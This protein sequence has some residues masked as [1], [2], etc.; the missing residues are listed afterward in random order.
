MPNPIRFIL[1]GLLA[2]STPVLAVPILS[3]AELHAGAW[4]ASLLEL[5]TQTSPLAV[6]GSAAASASMGGASTGIQGAAIDTGNGF[7][8]DFSFT[9][10][11]GAPHPDL[12]YTVDLQA[13]AILSGTFTLDAD[14]VGYTYAMEAVFDQAGTS[15]MAFH[16]YLYDLT[17]PGLPLF[18]LFQHNP[19]STDGSMGTDAGKQAIADSRIGWT[20]GDLIAGHSYGYVMDA[21]LGHDEAAYGETAAEA[22]GTFKLAIQGPAPEA[23]PEPSSLVL[24]GL[25]LGGLL[26]AA[27]KRSAFRS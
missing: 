14:D 23:V 9:G 6:G 1:P 15:M 5:D 22:Q 18:S 3:N 2:L 8:L 13:N 26:W 25:G 4:D 21:L 19:V 17:E 24:C 16:T 10:R 7:I 20:S 27:R 11:V 12:T